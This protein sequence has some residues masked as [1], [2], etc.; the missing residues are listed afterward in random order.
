[1]SNALSISLTHTSDS[2]LPGDTLHGQIHW[3]NATAPSQKVAVRLFWF[4]EGRGSQ[5]L[6]IIDELQLTLSP[7]SPTEFHFTLPHFPFSFSGKLIS[8]QWAVEAISLPDESHTSRH[9]FCLSPTKD[10]I[11]LTRVE[12]AQ[13]QQSKKWSNRK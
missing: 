5:D 1:M 13:T 10:E 2:Y 12:S 7:H 11:N 6:E 4:T 9:P 8:L 3:P